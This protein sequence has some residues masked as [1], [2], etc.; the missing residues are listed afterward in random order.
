[1]SIKYFLFLCF[2]FFSFGFFGQTNAEIKD[3][4]MIQSLQFKKAVLLVPLFKNIDTVITINK[5]L[6]LTGA[7]INSQLLEA[8]SESY[9]FSKVL[10]FYIENES[11]LSDSSLV[12]QI[13]FD[14]NLEAYEGILNYNKLFIAKFFSDGYKAQPDYLSY[15]F[16]KKKWNLRGKRIKPEKE[17][18][19]Y[20]KEIA[21]FSSEESK[22]GIV[23]SRLIPKKVKVRKKRKVF[24]N[25]HTYYPLHFTLPLNLVYQR[26]AESIEERVKEE[27]KES[28]KFFNIK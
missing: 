20:Q 10:F 12:D 9:S 24:Y 19:P 11:S 28:K 7:Y 22:T 17:L 15:Y 25:F 2:I 23:I 21:I 1:M 16:R 14:K 18:T 13:V 27:Y 3:E 26:A 8:F 4:Q 5:D 6:V